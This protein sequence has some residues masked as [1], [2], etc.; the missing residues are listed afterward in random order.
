M[1]VYNLTGILLTQTIWFSI[2][3]LEQQKEYACLD[4]SLDQKVVARKYTVS[5]CKKI[6]GQ[7]PAKASCLA[8]KT[9]KQECFFFK[10]SV[11]FAY[12]SCQ[13]FQLFHSI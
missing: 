12:S 8:N 2:K 9:N 5:H 10:K 4:P 11:L 7:L 6:F 13:D 1:H 3:A